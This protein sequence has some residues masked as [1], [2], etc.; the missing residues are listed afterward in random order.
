M[1]TSLLCE[2]TDGRLSQNLVMEAKMT[3]VMIRALA[4]RTK[5]MSQESRI[6]SVRTLGP[7]NAGAAIAG[8]RLRPDI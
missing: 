7:Q 4:V 2:I 6:R 1:G 8:G 5:T 3:K